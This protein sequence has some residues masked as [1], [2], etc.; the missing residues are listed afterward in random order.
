VTLP[1]TF[2]VRC[3]DCHSA[4]PGGAPVPFAQTAPPLGRCTHCHRSHEPFEGDGPYRE[5][6]RP[7]QSRVALLSSGPSPSQSPSDEAR[8][9]QSCHER[10]RPF[11][12][13]VYS[14]SLLLPFDANANGEAQ[15][16]EDADRRAGGIGTEA[17]LAFDVPRPERPA[18][19]FALELTS[20]AKLHQTG[21]IGTVHLG[22]G[23]VRVP[24]LAGVRASAPYLHN[25]SVPT[26]AQLLTP[27]AQRV[28]KFWVGGREIDPVAVG[29]VYDEG[30]NRSLLDT[31]LP[32][33]ANTGHAF[34]TQLSDAEKQ[35][36]LEYLKS[37]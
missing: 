9:C 7:G 15:G 22:A 14:S 30:P 33:N 19:G 37:L 12:P 35:D 11:E 36:L 13:V 8:L 24:P 32:G 4:T 26:L 20:L 16:D 17:L 23:W 31:S 2:P 25:G 10:H 21:P 18:S 1:A 3:G 28:S 29:N 27:P 6:S 5:R 34:G